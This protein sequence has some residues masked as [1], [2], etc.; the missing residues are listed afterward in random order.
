ML[1]V[2]LTGAELRIWELHG[3]G[4]AVPRIASMVVVPEDRVH[5]VIVNA[6][7]DDKQ[8][9]REGKRKRAA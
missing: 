4:F 3:Q 2:N 7:H 1:N 5:G 6:W 8:A 9:A